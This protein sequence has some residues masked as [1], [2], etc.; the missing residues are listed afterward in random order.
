MSSLQK[1][2]GQDLL[3]CFTKLSEGNETERIQATKL[4]LKRLSQNSSS[5]QQ[6]NGLNSDVK[7]SVN[8]LVQGLSSG[9]KFARQGFSTALCQ[10][11]R[12]MECIDSRLILSIIKEKSKLSHAGKPSKS[13]VSNILL[14]QVCGFLALIHSGRLF[15]DG[16]EA[17]QEVVKQLL[18]L[19]S[20]RTHLQQI[21]RSGIA[22]IIA[23]VSSDQFVGSVLPHLEAEF[24][25][26]WK[27]CV[28]D[29]LYLLLT[30]NRHHHS[31][32]KKLLKDSWS[33]SSLISEKNYPQV[34]NIVWA[35]TSCHPTIHNCINEILLTVNEKSEVATFW[36][37]VCRPLLTGDTKVSKKILALHM[38]E[39][40][41]PSLKDA[42]VMEEILVPDIVTVVA[43]L[44][45]KRTDELSVRIRRMMALLGRYVGES[46][47]ADL[48]LASLRSLMTTPGSCMLDSHTGT[49]LLADIIAKL[50]PEAQK[51]VLAELMKASQIKQSWI[52]A[53]EGRRLGECLQWCARE[54]ATLVINP[55][56][57]H[58]DMLA[59]LQLL[60]LRS[61]FTV[62]IPNKSI[63]FCTVLNADVQPSYYKCVLDTFMK[64]VSKLL[65][66]NIKGVSRL[67]QLNGHMDLMFSLLQY[68]QLLL[69]SPGHL[70]LTNPPDGLQIEEEWGQLVQ[71]VSEIDIKRKGEERLSGS[72]AFELLYF[73]TALQ[74]LIEPDIALETLQDLHVCYKRSCK[75]RKLLTK[76]DGPAWIEVVTE[77]LLSLMFKGSAMSRS[78]ANIVMA[79]LAEHVTPQ[80]LQLI[81]EALQQSSL[82]SEDGVVGV[83][84][85]MDSDMEDDM[86][87]SEQQ[88]EE[89]SSSEEEEEDGDDE[90][91]SGV[92]EES[93]SVPEEL[94][95]NVKA[96]L[97]EAAVIEGEDNSEQEDVEVS[98]SEMMQLDSMLAAAFRSMK[99]GKQV[100]KDKQRQLH[101]FKIRVL[102]LVD[103]LIKHHPTPSLLTMIVLPL[104]DRVV[105]G[106]RNQDEQT[107]ANRAH[108]TLMLLCKVKKLEPEEGSSSDRLLEVLQLLIQFAAKVSLPDLVTDVTKCC[109]LVIK[110]ILQQPSVSPLKT[111]ATAAQNT[112]STVRGIDQVVSMVRDAVF[113]LL[114]SKKAH[115]PAP[116][117]HTLLQRFTKLF[118]PLTKNILATLE[119]QDCKVFMKSQC[120]NFLLLMIN[121]QTVSELEAERW[122]EFVASW[123]TSAT[124]VLAAVN[125]GDLKKS[126][127]EEVLSVCIR[128]HQLQPDTEVLDEDV[129]ERLHS[130]RSH[131]SQ[132]SRAHLNKLMPDLTVEERRVKKGKKKEAKTWD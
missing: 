58:A 28:P 31:K 20:K 10:M 97:G 53:S 2:P 109:I 46:G 98:D 72:H 48:Q 90:E 94:K 101:T 36:K 5:E 62:T 110:T 3:S 42:S 122:S 13:E 75:K 29:T 40:L 59:C 25:Q 1:L 73:H 64:S 113:A 102:D 126:F 56:I 9:R 115:C 76:E 85:S 119:S 32:V 33:G 118:W 70:K 130:Q 39:S 114:N 41:L 45:P 24:H 26:G 106:I 107:L 38:F 27:A 96:A 21:C 6:A 82:T 30:A 81:V 124:K 54:M 15:L 66:V 12:V 61:F 69:T 111:R 11:L 35:S 14:G 99:R 51:K 121:K 120:A 100:D 79:T 43:S 78:V 129:L 50:L 77:L 65:T 91:D 125:E 86:D 37:C 105:G 132:T 116:L 22:Q 108:N 55:N 123:K 16:D 4:I 95:A 68:G 127:V 88:L 84:E 80:A 34:A 112:P 47:S 74:L 93:L 49:S 19:A 83:E 8:R 92:E 17:V 44:R 87:T 117:L 52:V 60:Y 104:V 7:Y 71:V 67:S 89:G 63:P 57:D 23:K 18:Q 128:V 103:M 131:L